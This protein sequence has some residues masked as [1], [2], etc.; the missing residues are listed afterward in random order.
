MGLGHEGV[1]ELDVLRLVF[2][3]LCSAFTQFNFISK[4]NLTTSCRLFFKINNHKLHFVFYYFDIIFTVMSFII[5]IGQLFS[6]DWASVIWCVL[7]KLVL[8]RLVCVCVFF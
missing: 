7:K 4:W 8:I 6:P 3:S 2:P 5:L 1:M